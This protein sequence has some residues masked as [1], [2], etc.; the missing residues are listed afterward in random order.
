MRKLLV[1]YQNKAHVV[2]E[3]KAI[4]LEG[5]MLS[6]KR[7]NNSRIYPQHVLDESVEAV[8]ERIRSNSFY[9]GISHDAEG[10]VALDR[11]S[12]IVTSLTK[13]SD[14]YVGRARIL[15]G[16]PA[17]NI[18][19]SIAIQHNGKIGFSSRGYGGLKKIGDL[20]EVQS[21]Y[22]L[23]AID[24]VSSPS[25]KNCWAHVI[26]ENIKTK[27]YNLCEQQLGLQILRE[28][29]PQG[30][31]LANA[32]QTQFDVGPYGYAWTDQ[33]D[34]SRDSATFPNR[35]QIDT[36]DI[37][38]RLAVLQGKPDFTIEDWQDAS[39][40][41]GYI[42]QVQDPMLRQ[43]LYQAWNDSVGFQ[44]MKARATEFL[45]RWSKFNR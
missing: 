23:A 3:K 31:S 43:Q 35:M 39:S 2:K 34:F 9:G 4:Y 29:G 6:S 42:S 12:H 1:E 25:G 26:H 11:A 40:M 15:T 7:N 24:T 14:G 28:M 41:R 27:T 18:L 37:L 36:N 22:T 19:E 30:T 38:D 8:Q 5:Q 10:S 33:G 17:G 32:S 44:Q 21:P 20:M 13:R 16:T 45:S